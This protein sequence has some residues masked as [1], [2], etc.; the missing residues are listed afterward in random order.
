MS[1]EERNPEQAI[2]E[3]REKR[4]GG[5][6]LDEGEREFLESERVNLAPDEGDNTPIA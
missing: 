6:D 3:I 4:D 2:E 1:D 5:N